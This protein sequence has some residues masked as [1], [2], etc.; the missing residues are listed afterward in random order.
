MCEVAGIIR[1]LADSRGG[2]GKHLHILRKLGA[3]YLV[4]CDHINFVHEVH[5]I[6]ESG[7]AEDSEHGHLEKYSN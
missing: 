6:D 1:Q 3:K 2:V 7:V 5:H 4:I